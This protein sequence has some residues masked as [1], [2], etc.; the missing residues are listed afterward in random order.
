MFNWSEVVHPYTVRWAAW[1]MIQATTSAYF[2]SQVAGLQGQLLVGMIGADNVAW[3]LRVE[4]DGLAQVCQTQY[5]GETM[6]ASGFASEFDFMFKRKV[7][8]IKCQRQFRLKYES[9]SCHFT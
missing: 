9:I 2:A 8:Q 6:C 4:G 1:P 7:F 3:H 5:H